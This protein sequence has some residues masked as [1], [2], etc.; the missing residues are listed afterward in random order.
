[1]ITVKTFVFNDIQVNTYLLIDESNECI[2]VD[3]ACYYE[4]EKEILARYIEDKKL[5]PVAVVITHG[6]FDHIPGN[7][8]VTTRFNIGIMV[9]PDSLNLLKLATE[10]GSVMGWQ[11]EQQPLPAR[12][13]NDG[14]E[15]QFGKSVL[16]VLATPGHCA[17][18]ICLLN[19]ESKFVITGDVLF[20]ESIG[21]TDLPTGDYDT[22][23][24]SIQNKL[25]VL[26]DNI[27]V[28]PGHGPSTSI[29]HEKKFN[30]YLS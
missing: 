20:Q 8:F 15:I 26:D 23:M 1:M 21:R 7:R 27:T 14:D 28:Y 19:E 9:H 11:I 13:L 5:K 17:G 25:M 18:S 2:I 6:H 29:G 16:K 22:L 12:I 24:E 30:P 4:E 3:P 10:Y